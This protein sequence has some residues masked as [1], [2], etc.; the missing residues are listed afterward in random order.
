MTDNEDDLNRFTRDGRIP[1]Y[2][3]QTEHCWQLIQEAQLKLNTISVEE[4]S[5]IESSTSLDCE[6]IHVLEVVFESCVHI[7]H[8]LQS[9][10]D[11]MAEDCDGFPD[12]LFYFLD[13]VTRDT[14]RMILQVAAAFDWRPGDVAALFKLETEGSD[15][16]ESDIAWEMLRNAAEHRALNPRPIASLLTQRGSDQHS[17]NTEQSSLPESVGRPDGVGL[18]S[19]AAVSQWSQYR[20]PAEW[21]KLLAE[22]GFERSERWWPGWRKQQG[23]RIEGHPKSCR[24]T[25]ELAEEYKLKLDEFEH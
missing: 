17:C 11:A 23:A 20:T 7:N 18:T 12:H 25:R 8:L 19:I 9:L 15:C 3:P 6:S 21:R 4:G 16:R 5:S 10:E 2:H 14:K 1:H 22:A 13:A 24:M